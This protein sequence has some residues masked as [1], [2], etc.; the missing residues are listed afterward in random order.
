MKKLFIINIV[1]LFFINSI[2]SQKFN[3]ELGLVGGLVSMQTDYGERSDFASSYGNIGYG[4]GGV[5]YISAGHKKRRWND[6]AM[7]GM[8]HIRLKAE[9]SYM[10]TKLRHRGA[11]TQGTSEQTLL[12]NALIGTSSILNYG[13]QFEYTV[14]RIN[15]DKRINPYIS[16]GVLLNSNTPKLESALGTI[17]NQNSNLIPNVYDNGIFLEKNNS[18]AI[19]FGFGTRI[20]SKDPYN[21]SKF[22]IDFRWQRFN[23]DTI[24]GLDPKIA[25]NKDADF[26]LYLS[27]GYIFSLN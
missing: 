10:Q 14:F 7:L 21:N 27:I 15:A 17:D 3:F 19:T 20:N 13:I 18:S 8:D 4:I 6:R 23:S 2:Y 26:L 22:L 25:A 11:Y 12:Y 9:I 16:L 1:S 5:Y 24:E